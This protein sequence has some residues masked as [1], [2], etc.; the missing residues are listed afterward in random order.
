MR[1]KPMHSPGSRDEIPSGFDLFSTAP[2]GALFNF[3]QVPIPAG[4]FSSKS[5]PF[6]QLVRFQGRPLPRAHFGG[7]DVTHVDTIVQRKHSVSLPAPYPSKAVVP[8]EIVALALESVEP[9]RVRVGDRTEFWDLLGELSEHRPSDG[10][11]TITKLNEEGG[12]FDSELTVFPV[13]RFV[14]RCDG[15]ERILDVGQLP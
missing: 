11:M 5:E 10:R 1:A 14:R 9:I 8:V 7:L 2:E 4:F 6:T 12:V 3:A 15:K 13:F